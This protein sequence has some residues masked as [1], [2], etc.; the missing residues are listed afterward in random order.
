MLFEYPKITIA[1]ARVNAGKT[2]AEAAK[3]LGITE[4]TLGAY[5]TGKRTPRWEI[6][7]AMSDL[8]GIPLDYLKVS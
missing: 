7:Q 1:A 5:E 3:A 8:Y 2:Q 6:V 4:K